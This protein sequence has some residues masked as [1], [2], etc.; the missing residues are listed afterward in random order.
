[1]RAKLVH[2]FLQRRFH[3]SLLVS[4]L[5]AVVHQ[6]VSFS[7]SIQELLELASSKSSCIDAEKL[8]C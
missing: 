7:A 8:T 1:M 2:F 6:Q 5:F 3:A 4:E